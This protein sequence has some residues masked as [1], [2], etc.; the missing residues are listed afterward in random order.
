MIKYVFIWLCFH[1]LRQMLCH[2]SLANNIQGEPK[3]GGQFSFSIQIGNEMPTV[4]ILSSECE[5]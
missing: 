4:N 5:P 2:S 3:K 1:T